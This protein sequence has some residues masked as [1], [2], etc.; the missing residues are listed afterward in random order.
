MSLDDPDHERLGVCGSNEITHCCNEQRRTTHLVVSSREAQN[1]C[2]DPPPCII[3]FINKIRSVALF[4]HCIAQIPF[5]TLE[6]ADDSLS[7][8]VS[9]GLSTHIGCA[10]RA[11]LDHLVYTVGNLVCV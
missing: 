9:L 10:D 2:H 4:Y 5:I 11:F 6:I 7:E 1:A 8:V 3:H